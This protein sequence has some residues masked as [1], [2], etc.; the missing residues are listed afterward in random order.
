MA[1][2]I[3]AAAPAGAGPP[4]PL[5][6]LRT[7][8]G[9]D[10]VDVSQIA[11][12]VAQ[13]CGNDLDRGVRDNGAQGVPRIAVVG[14]SVQDQ[15]RTPLMFDGSYRWMYATHCGEKFATAVNSGRIFDAVSTNPD[16]M[17][18]ALGANDMSNLWHVDPNLLPGALAT[19]NQ[20]L[21]A[22]E[23]VPCRVLINL[24]DVIP[25]YV[26]GQD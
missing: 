25:W 14:D 11:V 1:A 18:F 23:S 12:I 15:T 6:W 7:Y 24:P 2:V 5:P 13:E 20:M 21:D 9:P 26:T 22:T 10:S 8:V 4:D 19:F 16:V 3:G 17:V